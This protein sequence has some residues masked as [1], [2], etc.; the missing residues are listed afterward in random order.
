MGRAAFKTKDEWWQDDVQDYVRFDERLDEHAGSGP[1]PV[2]LSSTRRG[3]TGLYTIVETALVAASPE[4]ARFQS[5]AV[6]ERNIKRDGFAGRI[7]VTRRTLL[8][9]GDTTT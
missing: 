4:P 1:V 8:L 3:E 5:S 6:H 2:L 7:A 9:L